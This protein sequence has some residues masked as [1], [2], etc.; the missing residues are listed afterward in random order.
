MAGSARRGFCRRGMRRNLPLRRGDSQSPRRFSACESGFGVSRRRLADH[1]SIVIMRR[2]GM[3]YA[4]ST[5][6]GGLPAAS[7]V[8]LTSISALAT[9]CVQTV[10]P[11]DEI[12]HSQ[13]SSC[14]YTSTP[15]AVS[16]SRLPGDSPP[17][18]RQAMAGSCRDETIVGQ[19]RCGTEFWVHF[20]FSPESI[21]SILEATYARITTG[22]RGTKS[23][24]L[25]RSF[26]CPP[27][28]TCPPTQ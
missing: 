5:S 28:R 26:F 19:I 9:F 10:F 22:R 24:F 4:L 20:A 16:F 21:N 25:C 1:F 7:A 12:N 8:P 27:P 14:G 2:L 13:Y 18:R 23:L 11:F 15:T 6:P 3:G 17:V